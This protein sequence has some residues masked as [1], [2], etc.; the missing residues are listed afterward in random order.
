M[1]KFWI[2]EGNNEIIIC[3]KKDREATIKEWF[4]DTGRYLEDYDQTET[5]D[6]VIRIL[7]LVNVD[8]L[9]TPIEFSD[10]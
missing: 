10:E 5:N 7:T 4:T 3:R 1:A 6:K 2:F 9:K 8:C